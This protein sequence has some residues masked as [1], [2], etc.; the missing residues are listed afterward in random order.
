MRVAATLAALC[1]LIAAV[2]AA[3]LA[4]GPGAGDNLARR[5]GTGILLTLMGGVLGCVA[6]LWMAREP[7]RP[8]S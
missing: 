1:A 8:T 3:V 2:T 7:D 5:P 6:A 4:F